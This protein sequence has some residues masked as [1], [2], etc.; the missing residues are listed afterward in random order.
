MYETITSPFQIHWIYDSFT[1]YWCSSATFVIFSFSTTSHSSCSCKCVSVKEMQLTHRGRGKSATIWQTTFSNAFSWM[2]MYEFRLRFPWI[3][4]PKIQ[5]NNIPALIQIMA[6]RWPRDKP[7]F[8]Q[9][10]I[11]LLTHVCVT[12]PQCV[13]RWAKG[14]T[15]KTPYNTAPYITGSNIARF[16]HGSQNLWSKLWIPIVKS[17]PVRVIF[18]WKSVP[19]KSIH[20]SSDIYLG[21]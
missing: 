11:S 8:E 14:C 13:H 7:L 16:G 2:K 4:F 17:A 9:M 12:R 19:M 20:G 21:T 5:I 15:V 6:W 1:H 3:F 10:M 18:T